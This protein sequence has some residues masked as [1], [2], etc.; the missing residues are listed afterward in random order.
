VHKEHLKKSQLLRSN[1]S[2]ISS[3]FIIFQLH[4]FIP[5]SVAC[6]NIPYMLVTLETS[7]DATSLLN[8]DAP[9][10]IRFMLV[11]LDTSQD[12]ISL[13]NNDAYL[14]I[15]VMFVTLD[16][17]HDDILLLNDDAE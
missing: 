2:K 8:T 17:S 10:N 6:I 5:N 1:I 3:C 4:N 14:N 7:Q 12:D 13:L 16:M 11:T 15:A 9:S